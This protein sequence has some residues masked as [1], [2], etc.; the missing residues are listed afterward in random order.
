M[1]HFCIA[2]ETARE[3]PQPAFVASPNPSQKRLGSDHYG[4][5][6]GGGEMVT[7]YLTA[8]ALEVREGCLSIACEMRRSW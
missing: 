3:R 5:L 8:A 6:D 1:R 2:H 7:P 4:L